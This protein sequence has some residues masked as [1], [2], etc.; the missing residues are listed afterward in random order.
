MGLFGIHKNK[1]VS[2]TTYNRTVS[3]PERLLSYQFAN[4]QGIGKRNRQEDSFSQMNVLDVRKIKQE[5]LLFTVCDGMGGMVDGKVASETA[6]ESIRASFL[7]IDRR[8]NIAEQLADAVF[9]AGNAVYRK[10]DGD[11]G[12]TMVVCM[13]YDEKFYFASV[14]DSYLYLYRNGQLVRLNEMHNVCTSRYKEE[15]SDGGFDPFKGRNDIESEALTQFLGMDG[16]SEVDY[17]RK[18]LAVHSGD[19]FLA[20]SDGIGGVLE[21]CVLKNCL[22]MPTPARM[23]SEIEQEIRVINKPN[24]DNYTGVILKCLY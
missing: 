4:V 9:D 13:I 22:S 23:C 6:N 1:R 7:E 3:P 5:G 11:G 24:Q 8:K 14:G 12:T 2:Q 17:L 21:P 16:L 20:C 15:L 18:P 19:I 10:L